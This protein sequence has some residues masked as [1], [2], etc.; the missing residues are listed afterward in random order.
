MYRHQLAKVAAVY[1]G[2]PASLPRYD[3]TII[4]L[5]EHKTIVLCHHKTITLKKRVAPV[6]GYPRIVL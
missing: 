4:V 2:N 6:R 1:K 3:H 5:C